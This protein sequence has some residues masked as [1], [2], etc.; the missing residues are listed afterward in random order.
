VPIGIGATGGPDFFRSIGELDPG[1]A[2]NTLKNIRTHLAAGRAQGVLTLVNRTQEGAKVQLVRKN[3]FQLMFKGDDNERLQ[4]TRSAL[5]N[6]LWVAGLHDA[7]QK[8]EAYLDRKPLGER[9]RVSAKKLLEILNDHLDSTPSRATDPLRA[10]ADRVRSGPIEERLSIDLDE[11]PGDDEW[12]Q[13]NP[14][15]LEPGQRGVEQDPAEGSPLPGDG[16]PANSPFFESGSQSELRS[17]AGIRIGE[18]LGAGKFGVVWACTIA[19]D[20][21]PRV[22]KT[23]K[24]GQPQVLSLARDSSVNEAKAAY[25]TS[26]KSPD[27]ARQVNVAQPDFYLVEIGGRHRMVGPEALRKLIKSSPRGAVKSHATVL[28]RAAG[29][30][31]TEL[32][33]SLSPVQNRQVAR[34]ILQSVS[35]LNQRGLVHCDI[36]PDNAFFDPDSGKTTLIDTGLLQKLSKNKPNAQYLTNVAGTPMY[37][38]PRVAAG[39]P[40]G[41]EA[42]LHST[43]V[44]MLEMQHP[45][46]TF[47]EVFGPIS[48]AVRELAEGKNESGVER[49]DRDFIN[50]RIDAAM[51]NHS[52]FSSAH[53]NL[54]NMKQAIN[55]PATLSGFAMRCLDYAN[56]PAS[57]WARRGISQQWYGELLADP[58]LN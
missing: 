39:K 35:T 24:N 47:D 7:S 36:K 58:A 53:K 32:S 12:L 41:T 13:A 44:M 40:Y 21:T 6:L 5:R 27:Y 45:Q 52:R 31:I 18:A 48:T 38:H 9:N 56:R 51:K 42:D 30:E 10:T 8:L 26:S 4:D 2:R 22:M 15:S 28:P 43:A 37:L 3:R 57:E 14:E 25:L 16:S 17:K 19:G 54:R 50:R 29:Q 23:L 34:G 46:S 11:S 20:P 55:D 33:G 49:V 1:D